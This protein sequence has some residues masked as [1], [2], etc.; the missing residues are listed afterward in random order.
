LRFPHTAEGAP[1]TGSLR[2]IGGPIALQGT[3][4]LA[5]GGYELNA[6]LAPRD[7]ANTSLAQ[8]LSLL[9]PPDAQGR[10]QLSIA[11]TL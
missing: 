7:P 11:G 5:H 6:T 8:L 3:V 2:D 4:Q 10:H 1:N 9:G